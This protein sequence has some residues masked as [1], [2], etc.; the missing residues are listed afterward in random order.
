MVNEQMDVLRRR[1]DRREAVAGE[2]PT[3][4]TLVE[5]EQLVIATRDLGAVGE[6]SDD[7]V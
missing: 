5:H 2:L 1:Q 4:L 6:D 3:A 7:A